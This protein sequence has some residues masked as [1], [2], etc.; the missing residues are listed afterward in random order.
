[1]S[2][3]WFLIPRHRHRVRLH[4]PRKSATFAIRLVVPVVD[5]ATM[6]SHLMQPAALRVPIG[7]AT[8][9][10]FTTMNDVKLQTQDASDASPPTQRLDTDDIPCG[11]PLPFDIV[12]GAGMRLL[13]AGTVLP[14][15]DARSFLLTHFRPSRLVRPEP[16]ADTEAGADAA[17]AGPSENHSLAP[18]T[19][20]DM[21]IK[22]GA[23]LRIRMP[24]QTGYGVLN[25][26][27]IGVAPNRALF[28]TPPHAANQVE[29]VTLLFG[30]R[31]DV[32]YMNPRAVFDFVCTVDAVCRRP[33]DFL[34]LSPP[35]HIRRLR[36]RQ[37]TRMRMMLPVLY[38]NDADTSS[39]ATFTG[40]GMLRDVGAGGLSMAAAQEIAPE[41]QKIRIAC[42]IQAQGI[43]VN[44][45]TIGTIRNVRQ[46][47]ERS[48]W[49]IHGL[50][51]EDLDLTT[52]VALRCLAIE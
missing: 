27:V 48:P 10:P 18:I 32:L 19:F 8:Q 24:S 14:D 43:E 36:V 47:T 37:S 17:S 25:S 34:V 51:F 16:T 6:K 15:Q 44:L 2:P 41:G 5:Y 31:V 26:V 1:M 29:P 4:T 35:A 30:E 45:D 52:H 21:N 22:I 11:T 40:L 33:F 23:T 20:M 46:K 42:Q 39:N 13:K 50:E 28:V 9:P 7:I 12:N 38:R 49:V 3:V